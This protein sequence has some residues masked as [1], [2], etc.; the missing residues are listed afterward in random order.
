MNQ[1]TPCDD[2]VILVLTHAPDFEGAQ[3]IAR[4]LVSLGLA[5]C[6]NLG[7]PVV[8]IYRWE[9][10]VEQASE[11]AMT[12]KTTRGNEASLVRKLLEL[13]P[14]DVPECLVVSADGGAQAYLDWVRSS[15]S[16]GSR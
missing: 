7:P 9:G 5:A 15:M 1:P 12:I 13:H 16:Q 3:E 6:V 4:T 2:D 11:V 14:Y 8:S 10:E